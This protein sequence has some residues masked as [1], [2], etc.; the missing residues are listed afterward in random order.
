MPEHAILQTRG[1]RPVQGLPN[2]RAKT[3]SLRVN[4]ESRTLTID[5]STTLLDALRLRL[6]LTGTKKG[7]RPVRRLHCAG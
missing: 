6:G 1:A 7:P 5:P 2:P 4:G 3:V